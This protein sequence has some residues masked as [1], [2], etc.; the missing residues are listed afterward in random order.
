MD[1]SD[2]LGKDIPKLGFGLM[3]L[4]RVDGM[5]SPVDKAVLKE[6]VDLFMDAGFTYF[7]TAYGYEDSEVSIK[8]ALVDR[9]PRASYQLATKLPA[10]RSNTREGAE[11][12]FYESLERTG[13]GYFD[14]YLLHNIG[15][16]R[17]AVF[18]EFDTW[19]F[20]AER[21]AEGLIRHLG[22]S[23]H[24][25]ATVLDEVLTEHPEMEFVQLQINY[26]DWES[27]S[28]QSRLCYET[29]Q[30]HNKPIILMEPVKGGNLVSLPP[31]A[32]AELTAVNPAP[33]IASWALRYAG[34]LD[35]IITV[36]S[37]MSNLE[38]MRDN[39]ATFTDFKPLTSE[40]RTAIHRTVIE[41]EKVPTVPCTS[42]G[43]CLDECSE[44]VA[45]PGIFETMNDLTLYGNKGGA[46]FGYFW[47][48]KGHN[49]GRASDCIQC[50]SCEAV[51]P[52]EIAI[53]DELERA[54]G[55]FEKEG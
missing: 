4:P 1:Y 50:G 29:A 15:A 16:A 14:Y 7:D 20:L 41:I 19:S 8:E 37:G 22:F 55:I 40:E 32:A 45:I 52:Q 5:G 6:M 33:S 44:H 39:I 2:Y 17:R 31:A 11:A 18:D 30:R 21:K 53:I 42:C 9:Y 46:A 49:R 23:L 36:L 26:A 54:V 35:G 3:R 51:C 10:W 12:L 34:S 28:V 43:Y 27:P 13:A 48:T 47:Q 24:D 25:T 38:Q